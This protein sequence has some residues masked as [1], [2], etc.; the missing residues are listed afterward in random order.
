MATYAI[1]DIQGCFA[2]LQKLLTHIEFNPVEDTLWFTGDLVNRGPRSLDVLRF[3]KD[4]GDKHITVLGNHDLHLLAIAYGVRTA[5]QGDTLDE[6]LNAPDKMELINWLRTRPLLHADDATSFVMT[7]RTPPGWDIQK[8]TWVLS[9][10]LVCDPADFLLKHTWNQ[11]DKWDGTDW[12][13]VCVVSL[14]I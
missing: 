4:L 12:L 13:R 1:G 3:I 11:P 10:I 8:A 2:E 7:C 6:I 14:I 5:H 9:E